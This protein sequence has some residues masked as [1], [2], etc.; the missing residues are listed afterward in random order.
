MLIGLKSAVAKAGRRLQAPAARLLGDNAGN[1]AL[2]FA[3][4][5]TILAFLGV[6][7]FDFGRYGLL[8]TRAFNSARAGTQYGIQNQGTAEDLAG[9]VSAAR[10]DAGDTGNQL[11]IV[12]R[13]FCMCPG[14]TNKL[15]CATA[16]ANCADGRYIPIFVEVTVRDSLDLFFRYPGVSEILPI[17]TQSEMRVR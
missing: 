9:M 16:P 2:E 10:A 11:N 7:M 3:F 4:L 8:Y 17:T 15:D 14:T 5:V 13:Q 1:A 6:G 12:A